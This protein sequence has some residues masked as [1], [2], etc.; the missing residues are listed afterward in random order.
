M[1]PNVTT[2]NLE[3]P[4]YNAYQ[5]TLSGDYNTNIDTNTAPVYATPP[6]GVWQYPDHSAHPQAV[7]HFVHPVAHTAPQ[8]AATQ[9]APAQTEAPRVFTVQDLAGEYARM[10]ALADAALQR[11]DALKKVENRFKELDTQYQKLGGEPVP[12]RSHTVKPLNID[13]DI[14]MANADR[15]LSEHKETV[16]KNIKTGLGNQFTM[17]EVIRK[18]EYV[19]DSYNKLVNAHKYTQANSGYQR[20]QN[21]YRYAPQPA[22]NEYKYHP[23]VPQPSRTYQ[24]STSYIHTRSS[25][26]CSVPLVAAAI[27]F[28]VTGGN[29]L[30]ASTVGLL[31]KLKGF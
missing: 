29:F 10:G 5:N 28:F 21:D 23:H 30:F 11:E 9:P 14:S 17:K 20:P 27:T 13:P 4:M 15:L 2:Q 26:D 12:M 1:N 16:E 3:F 18:Q 24:A 22:R 19:N 7:P 31:A 8:P 25:G 6:Q